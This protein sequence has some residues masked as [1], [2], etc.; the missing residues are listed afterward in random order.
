MHVIWSKAI[1]GRKRQT[2]IKNVRR[3][4]KE[5]ARMLYDR[6]E[7]DQLK[8]FTLNSQDPSMIRWYRQLCESQGEFERAYQAYQAANDT[9][10]IT[11][12]QCRYERIDEAVQ[13]AK[14]KD[15]KAA[16][17]HAALHC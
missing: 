10:N 5:I 1:P 3:E 11:R 4:K 2:N 8:S 15:N 9:L 13:L 17:Y 12:M 16:A 6:R 7:Y 14:G